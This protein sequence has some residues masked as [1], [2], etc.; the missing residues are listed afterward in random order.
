MTDS[1]HP[2]A[3]MRKGRLILI[4]LAAAVPGFL[5]VFG[6]IV[7]AEFGRDPLGL[8]KLDGLSRLYGNRTR[9]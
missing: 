5:I 6:A 8:G 2:M 9:R 1:T 4:T 3:P 7:P